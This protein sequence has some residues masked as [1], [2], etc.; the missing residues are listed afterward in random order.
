MGRVNRDIS[1]LLGK[2]LPFCDGNQG[3]VSWNHLQ[4]RFIR[5]E[6]KSLSFCHLQGLH[7]LQAPCQ[8]FVDRLSQVIQRISHSL[9]HDIHIDVIYRTNN[10]S[11]LPYIFILLQIMIIHLNYGHSKFAIEFDRQDRHCISEIQN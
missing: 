8:I 2:F 7:L 3:F 11:L 9:G 4:H 5:I 10:S 1:T 6:I